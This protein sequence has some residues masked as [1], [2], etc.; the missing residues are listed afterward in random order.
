MSKACKKISCRL[1]APEVS[2]V[3]LADF[4]IHL[5][6]PM[7]R[8][9]RIARPIHD[10]ISIPSLFALNSNFNLHRLHVLRLPSLKTRR[11]SDSLTN[12]ISF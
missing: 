5:L 12:L 8:Q 2:E 7:L 6:P 9:W 1:D 11:R 4:E 10:N 3:R